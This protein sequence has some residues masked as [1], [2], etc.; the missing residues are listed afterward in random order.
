ML[1]RQNITAAKLFQRPTVFP[2]ESLPIHLCS[3]KKKSQPLSI[4]E[5]YGL[6]KK[7]AQFQTK[8]LKLSTTDPQKSIAMLF[9]QLQAL[10]HLKHFIQELSYKDSRTY[11]HL[12]KD[13]DLQLTTTLDDLK[14]LAAHHPIDP[15]WFCKRMM[16]FPS[17]GMEILGILEVLKKK[18]TTA[19]F[20]HVIKELKHEYQTQFDLCESI[21]HE[22][23]SEPTD[24]QVD[25]SETYA[26]ELV[27]ELCYNYSFALKI[28]ILLEG[29]HGR[30]LKSNL[31]AHATDPS[32]LG[33]T[34]YLLAQW[35]IFEGALN[36]LKSIPTPK[37]HS[38]RNDDWF[39]CL[40]EVLRKTGQGQEAKDVRWRYFQAKPDHA[41]ALF[42]LGPWY[43]QVDDEEEAPE[44]PGF[45]EDAKRI[46]NHLFE[47]LSLKASLSICFK[48]T[49][50]SGFETLID[51][52]MLRHYQGPQLLALPFEDLEAYIEDYETEHGEYPMGLAAALVVYRTLI[53]RIYN[54]KALDSDQELIHYINQAEEL[55][56][57]LVRDSASQHLPSHPTFMSHLTTPELPSHLY[58][59]KRNS[60]PPNTKEFLL[61][62]SNYTELNTKAQQCSTTTP[63]ESVRMLLDQIQ[64]LTGLTDYLRELSK[65]HHHYEPILSDTEST[66][67]NTEQDLKKLI[68]KHPPDP[69]WFPTRFLELPLRGIRHLYLLE[70]LADI[71][72]PKER[73]EALDFLQSTYRY[74]INKYHS[75][76][77]HHTP[78]PNHNHR[79]ISELIEVLDFKF[80]D[81]LNFAL[82]FMT[83]LRGDQASFLHNQLKEQAKDSEELL[84][85]SFDL[86]DE[87]LFKSALICLQSIPTPTPC[88]KNKP[89]YNQC[90]WL[91]REAGQHLE[92]QEL[93]WEYFQANKSPN[94]VEFYLSPWLVIPSCH[95][96][97][98][99]SQQ[100]MRVKKTL[101]E[102]LS[103]N[104]CLSV[105]S[106]LVKIPGFATT[107]ND[108]M[109]HYH[110]KPELSHG[111]NDF[112][113]YLTR[114]YYE[115]HGA[116]GV[117]AA[118]IACRALIQRRW[119]PTLNLTTKKSRKL[120]KL[121]EKA[122]K[123]DLQ[124]KRTPTTRHIPS[125]RDFMALLPQKKTPLTS[126]KKAPS[127]ERSLHV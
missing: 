67:K 66:L 90:E 104:K 5:Y 10:V 55:D 9:D 51:D 57:E 3:L 38:N 65:T 120:A 123:M 45:L 79:D 125:H 39:Y 47:K 97:P 117:L 91:L 48:L 2:L 52:L 37:A 35:G 6:L 7:Y 103:F 118:L 25:P 75:P 13:T 88:H 8:A 102:E 4:Q 19:Q 115:A 107:F 22:L 53:Q 20:S 42:Y 83:F 99:Y 98:E 94:G 92:A 32:E 30:F 77:G 85:L 46:Q 89:W 124:F 70:M 74:Y 119:A 27:D 84:E 113:E 73:D 96:S 31:G 80:M 81:D 86:S 87:K 126:V 64:G 24:R 18:W 105:C 43:H 82:D 114:Y 54:P 71:W 16:K 100:V 106:Y 28:F 58:H 26:R 21:R 14:E 108:L 60:N 11:R 23:G 33:A 50:R 59:V 101:I 56:A 44:L 110:Q 122:E 112:L 121:I 76:H 116:K 17:V 49:L 15:T 63:Q 34:S 109:L 41:R 29:D 93:R 72:G 40:D 111:T 68:Q 127:Q 61:L 62:H 95:D 1:D 12:E 36:C 69:K 78:P